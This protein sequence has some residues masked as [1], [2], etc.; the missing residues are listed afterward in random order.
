MVSCLTHVSLSHFEFIFVYSVR[1]FSDFI[2]L[3]TAV[4]LTQHHLLKGLSFLHCIF[5]PPLLTVSVWIYF[6]AFCSVPLIHM[7][8]FLCQ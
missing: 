2:N 4:Q 5:L 8:V 6:G 1:E 3:H 7:S